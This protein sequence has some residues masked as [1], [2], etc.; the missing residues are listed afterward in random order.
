MTDIFNQLRSA[1]PGMV[2]PALP[3]QPGATTLALQHQ[4]DQ[5]QWWSPADL[6]LHQLAQLRLVLR[7]AI[8]T[9]PYWG[10]RLGKEW[11]R[12]DIIPDWTRFRQLPLMTRADAQQSGND[13]LSR[14]IPGD[15]GALTRS[16]S[17]GSTGMPLTC[18]GTALTDFFW[19]AF[20]LREHFWHGRDFSGR[21]AAIRLKVNS[22][23]MPGWGPATDIAFTT[24]PCALLNLQT[25]IDTQLDWLEAQSAQYLITIATNLRWLAERAI[26]RKLK[27]PGLL[28]ARSYGGIV[29][30]K[31]RDAVDAAWQVKVVDMYTAKEVGY[32][33]L[34]CPL[35][36]HYHVQSENL[37]VEIL[38]DSGAPCP[39]GEVGRVVV[40]TLHNFA[41]PLIRYEIGDFAEAGDA[42]ECG[43]G[44]PVLRRIMGRERNLLRLPDGQ[45]HWPSFP[46]SRWAAI[47]PIR[48]LQLVQKS[49]QDIRV[50][51]VAPRDLS[52]DE[53]QRLIA[54]LQDCLGYPF[55][56]TVARVDEIARAG[57]Y[58]FEDFVSEC[59]D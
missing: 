44:L 58:K 14:R 16:G 2:W 31:T 27:L 3:D 9:V 52:A 32:I 23:E 5:S 11:R 24:G 1:V 25:D 43:R 55:R 12:D 49:L 53:A 50:R 37:I 20:T 30:D 35:H 10:A 33:A 40:T 59:A 51:I 57:N 26:E 13:L 8:E 56:M 29:D 38:D 46:Q 19:R 42:C 41:M 4:L 54:V 47:A 28:E 22:G 7:H 36:A 48:Q 21:L 17:S 45:R 15:H 34:Q 6:Q 18:Y 39:P